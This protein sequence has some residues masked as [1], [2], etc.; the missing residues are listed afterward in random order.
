MCHVMTVHGPIDPS[1]LGFTLPHEHT[2]IQLWQIPGRWDYWELTRDEPV[3]L[4][5]LRRYREAG[6]SA[7][8][9]VT[10]DGV[11][12]DPM[13]LRM[14]ADRSGLQVVMGCGWY[15]GAYY[16]ADLLVERRGVAFP[17]GGVVR[18]FAPAGAA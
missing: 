5:E 4:E 13:W 9:D 14:L 7:L 15:R 10:I 18:A 17:A 2:Q 8:V 3:I 12:R 16:P 1:A 6:G 11:G